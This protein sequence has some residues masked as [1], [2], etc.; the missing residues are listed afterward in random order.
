MITQAI[1]LYSLSGRNTQ[2]SSLAKECAEKL[3]ED[4]NYEDALRFYEKAAQLYEIDNNV[5]YSN[6]M[7]AKWAD[8]SILVDNMKAVGKIIKT[9]DK[10]G[11][12]YLSTPL[13]KSSAK[14]YFF[15]VCLCFLVND[16]MPGAKKSIENFCYEDPNFD[17]SK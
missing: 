4:Y 17:T 11:K 9:Y 13:I 2:S 6:Q 8:L 12:K 5:S 1:E 7:L 10:I 16:D 15:K 14:D 3:E